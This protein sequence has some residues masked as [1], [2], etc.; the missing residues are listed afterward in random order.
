MEAALAKVGPLVSR[1]LLSAI[2]FYSG[3]Q[4]LARPGRVA[5]N[6]AGR[7]LPFATA[8]AY[9]ASV[10]EL[11]VGAAVVVGLRARAASVAVI[12]YLVVVT[13]LFHWQPAVRGEAQ[14]MLQVLKN[15]GMAGGFLLLATHGPGP[16]SLDRG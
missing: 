11:L 10:F 16:A 12:V 8:G 2:F 4:K 3:Y 5:A 13:Y 9:G 6:I 15:A 1:V 14:Q 7:G